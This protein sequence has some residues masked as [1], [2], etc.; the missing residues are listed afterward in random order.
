GFFVNTLVLRGD[1][2]RAPSFRELLARVRETSLAAHA[3]QDLPFEK[4]VQELSPERS[5]AHSPLFQV[6]LVLQNAPFG[7]LEIERLLLSTL[8]SPS[9]GTIQLQRL[10]RAACTSCSPRRPGGLWRPSR[11]SSGATS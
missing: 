4:L 10:P 6:M 1:L 8:R 11:W 7:K 3:H 9:R 2:S 5:L